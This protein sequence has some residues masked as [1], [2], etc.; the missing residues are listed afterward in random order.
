[1]CFVF[2]SQL[3]SASWLVVG[4]DGSGKG[5]QRELSYSIPLK[6]ELAGKIYWDQNAVLKTAASSVWN[7][8]HFSLSQAIDKEAAYV[9]LSKVYSTNL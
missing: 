2:I 5:K 4:C 8:L 6:I 7:N 1:M 9:G 3:Y